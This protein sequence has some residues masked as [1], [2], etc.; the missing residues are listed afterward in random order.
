VTLLALGN[1]AADVSAT[2]SAFQMDPENGYNLSLGALTGAGMFVSTVV[3]GAVIVV[4]EGVPCRGALVRDVV[5]FA[6]TTIAVY[7]VLRGGTVGPGAVTSF[8]A[9]YGAF[10][11]VVLIADVYHRA[12]VVPRLRLKEEVRERTRQDTE[13]RRATMAA[14]MSLNSLAEGEDGGEEGD[15][16]APVGAG[17][18]AGAPNPNPT[19]TPL[20][21]PAF[22]HDSEFTA[23]EG[24]G[25]VGDVPKRGRRRKIVDAVLGALS[26][27]DKYDETG[28]D[29]PD[30][31]SGAPAAAAPGEGWGVQHEDGR[32]S[33]RPVVLHGKDGV[34]NR[35]RGLGG[36][37]GGIHRAGNDEMEEDA[38]AVGGNYIGG[39][40]AGGDVGGIL[41][42]HPYSSMVDGVCSEIGTGSFS[43]SN[44][45]G[46]FH[47]CREELRVHIKETW[48]GIFDD[49]DANSSLDKFLL[50]CE[51]PFTAM[52]KLSVPIPCEGY[53]CR[54]VVALA[55]SASPVWISLYL[56]LQHDINLFWTG[57]FPYVLIMTIAS[58]TI[59]TLVARFAPGG[60]GE[61]NLLFSGP[62]AFYGFVIAAMWIDAIADQLVGLLGL[63]GTLFR[64]PG[65][66]MGL[67]LLA[68]GNS[69]GDLSANMTMARKGLG[70]MAITACFA[71]P[72]FN[73]LIGLGGGFTLLSGITGEAE[74]EV[75]LTPSVETGFLFLVANCALVLV[76][77]LCVCGG[78][79]PAGYGYAALSLYGAYVVTSLILQFK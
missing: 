8:F 70:N 29:D 31:G 79:I 23:A 77:G 69:M 13:G 75:V 54:A 33:E 15:D 25:G 46:A 20:I 59:G 24:A 16:A 57:G 61:M 10:V 48:E 30:S 34:L 52:R 21:E 35:H 26:N 53:Y 1:G 12:V 32:A 72:V 78:Y 56:L 9:M 62:L 51:L 71:G 63:L 6:I 14:G 44:W 73:I 50:T 38:A 39:P 22:S 37:I 7:C 42:D 45:R 18:T 65:S 64:V 40:L 27:Y 76:A 36:G 55:V 3:A 2:M 49:D 11:A 74:K 67:T 17:P 5:V 43:A 47:D 58:C 28:I 60:D 66:I 41:S 68:W 19:P 4:A